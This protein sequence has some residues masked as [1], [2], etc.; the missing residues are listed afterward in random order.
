MQSAIVAA[1][2]GSLLVHSDDEEMARWRQRL[3]ATIAAASST[4]SRFALVVGGGRLAREMI[5]VERSRGITDEAE[6]DIVGIAATRTNAENLRGLLAEAGID[7]AADIPS[8]ISDA[9]A[10]L[11]SHTVVVMGGTI[12]GH[13]TDAVAIMLG[14]KCAAQRV[15]IA[16]NVSHVY[17]KDPRLDPTARPI[18]SLTLTELARISGSEGRLA[19]GSSSAVDPIGVVLAMEAGMP[20]AVL[21]G[22]DAGLLSKALTG[23]PFAGT[24]VLPGE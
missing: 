6:L 20:L 3:C 15:L 21:D 12:P 22:R 8:S 5:A 24:Q 16:T 23:R 19:A 7:V 10:A 9:A 4:G 1:I 14:I 11:N 17:T 13:T 2:G 18:E